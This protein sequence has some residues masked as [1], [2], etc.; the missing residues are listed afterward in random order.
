MTHEPQPLSS[1]TGERV[2]IAGSL[3]P[4]LLEFS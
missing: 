4:T 3:R 2:I 1:K